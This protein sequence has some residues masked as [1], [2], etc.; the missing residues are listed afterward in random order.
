M[1]RF[2]AC[3]GNDPRALGIGIPVKAMGKW[4]ALGLPPAALRPTS[5]FW[6][7]QDLPERPPFLGYWVNVI[8]GTPRFGSGAPPMSDMGIRGRER[9]EGVRNGFPTK[10]EDFRGPGNVDPGRNKRPMSREV[11]PPKVV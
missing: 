5:G 3:A 4:M 2:S 9:D 1:F 7:P 8:P 10:W 6:G 11:T